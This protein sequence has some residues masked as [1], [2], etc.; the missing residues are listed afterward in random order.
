MKA[1]VNGG[2][3]SAAKAPPSPPPPPAAPLLPGHCGHCDLDN[4]A[5]KHS[6]SR[7]AGGVEDGDGGWEGLNICS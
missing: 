3:P 7:G 2:Q 4:E 1:Q 5:Q 6:F